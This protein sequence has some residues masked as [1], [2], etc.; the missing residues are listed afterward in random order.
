MNEILFIAIGVLISYNVF[1]VAISIFEDIKSRK[2]YVYDDRDT[3]EKII[4]GEDTSEVALDYLK[5]L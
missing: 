2:N 3:D 1:N 5:K 4:A